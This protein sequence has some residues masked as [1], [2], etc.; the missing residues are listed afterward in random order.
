MQ[1]GALIHPFY[2]IFVVQMEF[3]APPKLTHNLLY[4]MH[5]QLIG[6]V[7]VCCFLVFQVR[8]VL[9][10]TETLSI[11]GNDLWKTS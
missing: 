9:F 7:S 5:F 2:L 8:T 1:L 3:E 11:L 10:T 4:S 6:E